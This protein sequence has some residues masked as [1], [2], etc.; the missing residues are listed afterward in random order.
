[1]VTVLIIF[2]HFVDSTTKS[3][4]LENKHVWITLIIKIMYIFNI[5]RIQIAFI[6]KYTRDKKI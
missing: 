1:M 5:D 3:I 2:E 4:R 6:N